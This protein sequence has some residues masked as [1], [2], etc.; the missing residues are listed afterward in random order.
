[1][2][3]QMGR[4]LDEGIGVI[5]ECT[6]LGNELLGYWAFVLIV[7]LVGGVGW[8]M[9]SFEVHEAQGVFISPRDDMG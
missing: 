5:T 7:M 1:M 8:I 3:T 4:W 9:N 2:G 6:G